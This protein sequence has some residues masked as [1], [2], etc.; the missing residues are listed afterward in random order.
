MK[1]I[2]KSAFLLLSI[3][4]IFSYCQ[5]QEGEGE[6]EMNEQKIYKTPEDAALNAKSDLIQVLET[7]KDIDLGI[8]V[9]KLRN[10]ELVRLVK[11]QEVDFEKMLTTESIQSLS[12]ISFPNKSMV[13]P[14]ILDDEVVGVAEVN[15]VRDGWK[16]AGLGNKPITDDINTTRVNLNNNLEVTIYEVPNL[17]IYIYG[18]RKE[19]AETYYLNFDDFTLKDSTALKTFYPV[20]RESSIRF[21]KEFGEQLKK[22]KLV[23]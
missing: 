2:L 5:S 19:A 15:E 13:A 18:V 3:I 9:A 4:F 12:E 23:K 14:F 6:G 11:Y 7:N 20:V 21:Q 22:E 17:Q 10:A 1:S 8:D 16:V